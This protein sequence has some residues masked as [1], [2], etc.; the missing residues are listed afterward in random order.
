MSDRVATALEIR[1]KSGN[2]REKRGK[3][4]EKSRNLKGKKRK[5][6]GQGIRKVVRT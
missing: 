2:L 1:G 4:Q 3:G 6:R 5:G